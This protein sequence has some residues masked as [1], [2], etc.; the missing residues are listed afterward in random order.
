MKITRRKNLGRRIIEEDSVDLSIVTIDILKAAATTATTIPVLGSAAGIVSCILQQISQAQQ[1]TELSLKITTRC[2]RALITISEHLDTL[3]ITPAILNNIKYLVA[4]LHE[5]Q[6]FV[7]KETNSNIFYLILFAR[8]R[9]QRLQDL[10]LRVQDTMALFQITTLI[11]LRDIVQHH[12]SSLESGI[13]EIRDAVSGQ[14]RPQRM[15]KDEPDS[16]TDEEFDIVPE[17]ELLVRNGLRLHSAKV[18]GKCVVV[19]VFEGEHALKNYRATVEFEKHLL[20]PHLLRLKHISRTNTPTPFIVYHQDVQATAERVIAAAIPLGIFSTFVAG[21]QLASGI[22]S[23]LSHLHLR[24][25]PLHSVGIENFTIFMN[26]AN[27][28]ILSFDGIWNSVSVACRQDD[29]GLDVLGELC[30]QTFN[31]AN[32]IS[33]KNANLFCCGQLS[34]SVNDTDD[35]LVHAD[36]SESLFISNVELVDTADKERTNRASGEFYA[37]TVVVI[38]SSAHRKLAWQGTGGTGS[39]VTLDD[40][41]FHFKNALSSLSSTSYFSKDRARSIRFQTVG[42]YEEFQLEKVTFGRVLSGYLAGTVSLHENCMICGEDIE[43]GLGYRCKEGEGTLV[44][45][46]RVCKC[47]AEAAGGRFWS[48]SL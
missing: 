18:N 48:D 24:G 4:D 16:W 43:G 11:T 32:K 23:A 3:E 2:A 35:T 39:S 33:S 10:Q 14:G 6:G 34:A 45:S 8:K 19:K 38:L 22:A 9:A 28:A 13:L 12:S 41:S 31:V 27:K 44:I 5:V 36:E 7:D 40:I 25:I 21:A 37:V 47:K 1:N 17:E 15:L 29:T 42:E 46:N 26:G 20:H 30:R